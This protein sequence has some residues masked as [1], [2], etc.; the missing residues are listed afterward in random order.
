AAQ[1]APLVYSG[2][3]VHLGTGEV[4]ADATVVVAQG[5]IVSAG[6][7]AAPAGAQAIDARGMVITPGFVDPLTQVGLIE[8]DL[9]E[10]THDDRQAGSDRIRAGF[11]SADGY[12][13]ASIVIP[14]TR[15][16]GLTSVGVVP[17]GGLISGISAW[18][19]LDGAT[20]A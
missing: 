2:A 15:A 7:G 4:I 16:E 19:D 1:T 10:E 13:P 9:E 5:K 17:Q 3:T 12:N 6:K 8:V 20:A 18:A 14:V 11:R